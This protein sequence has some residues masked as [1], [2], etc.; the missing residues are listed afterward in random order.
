[1][2]DTFWVSHMEQW[3]AGSVRLNLSVPGDAM[4]GVY[5]RKGMP[6]THVQF[7]F[8]KVI[9]GSRVERSRSKRATVISCYCT[10][11]VKINAKRCDALLLV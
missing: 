7:D 5:G 2:P 3:P 8:F 10:G 11:A 6:P 9:D 4:V 1:M